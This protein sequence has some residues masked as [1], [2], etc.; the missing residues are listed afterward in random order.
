MRRCIAELLTIHGYMVSS[1]GV[2]CCS[3]AGDATPADCTATW[4]H[5]PRSSREWRN[6]DSRERGDTSA[7]QHTH[8]STT[9]AQ[10]TTQARAPICVVAVLA[11]GSGRA[12]KTTRTWHGPQMYGP[13]I[14]P[15]APS[16]CIRQPIE[17]TSD[18]T[19]TVTV[20][21]GTC[22]T[23]LSSDQSLAH[24]STLTVTPVLHHKHTSQVRISLSSNAS[25]SF[26]RCS[27]RYGPHWLFPPLLCFGS[28][29]PSPV[30]GQAG[31]SL[32]LYNDTLCSIPYPSTE[33]NFVNV[34]FPSTSSCFTAPF[35]PPPGAERS[36]SSGMWNS[37]RG[38]FQF[39][40][41]RYN[42]T[43]ATI[44]YYFGNTTCNQASYYLLLASLPH[45]AWT[46][47]TCM[48]AQS[49][50]W[51]RVLREGHCWAVTL[52]YL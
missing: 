49:V 33:Y 18:V 35:Q 41:A 44:S 51:W 36:S 3:A 13:E 48:P 28:I 32:T 45:A 37:L 34:S 7:T 22:R 2:A 50:W 12:N 1:A 15:T 52:V 27:E 8:R 47:T 11:K 39:P 30:Y 40:T 31:V 24:C 17:H 21:T 14:L 9:S 4:P 5:T 16:L 10:P 23:G 19:V 26:V 43:G 38:S 20:T 6:A 29:A 46:P 42:Q 25:F